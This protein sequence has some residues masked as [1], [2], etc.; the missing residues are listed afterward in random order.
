MVA[1]FMAHCN[2]GVAFQR[3]CLL[4]DRQRLS[5]QKNTTCPVHAIQQYSGSQHHGACKVVSASMS[6]ADTS[7]SSSS[8]SSSTTKEVPVKRVCRVCKSMYDPAANH[9]S[10]CV[11]HEGYY[12]G[13]L[14]RIE[15]TETSGLEYF[16]HCC[17]QY[18]QS[19]PGCTRSR[20]KSYDDA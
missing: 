3:A 7:D 4:R 14:N 20:H 2:N 18:D 13:R 12:A 11:Y 6:V 1:L 15:P 8:R 9:D 10:A 5:P 17:G 19:A 16:W